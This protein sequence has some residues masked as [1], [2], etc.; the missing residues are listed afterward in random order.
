MAFIVLFIYFLIRWLKKHMITW[1]LVLNKWRLMRHNTTVVITEPVFMQAK[2]DPGCMCSKMYLLKTSRI[3]SYQLKKHGSE[4][5]DGENWSND[6]W[7]KRETK[8][9]LYIIIDYKPVIRISC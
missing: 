6:L 1:E 4:M 5:T 7:S 2:G 3:P 8:E 9:F